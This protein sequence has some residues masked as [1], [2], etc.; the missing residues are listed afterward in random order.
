LADMIVNCFWKSKSPSKMALM[1]EKEKLSK[2][3]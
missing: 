1:I 3:S 2:L